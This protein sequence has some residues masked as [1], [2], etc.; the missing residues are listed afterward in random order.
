M[1]HWERPLPCTSGRIVRR[2]QV[3]LDILGNRMTIDE[4]TGRLLDGR[5]QGTAKPQLKTEWT[6]RGD[7]YF[8]PCG[9]GNGPRKSGGSNGAA[10]HGEHH[11]GYNPPAPQPP[12]PRPTASPATQDLLGGIAADRSGAGAAAEGGGR[13]EQP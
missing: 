3:V 4:L 6:A 12:R 9:N 8:H 10:G 5:Y 13:G 7:A 11:N 2:P 1:R